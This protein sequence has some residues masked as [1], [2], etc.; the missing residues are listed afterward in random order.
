M[1]RPSGDA[2]QIQAVTSGKRFP[3]NP[4]FFRERSPGPRCPLNA[5]LHTSPRGGGG[6][7]RTFQ[8]RRSRP[9]WSGWLLCLIPLELLLSL[10]RAC[11]LEEG[12]LTSY[13]ECRTC[14]LGGSAVGSAPGTPWCPRPP[15]PVSRHAPQLPAE[16]AVNV[17]R[18]FAALTVKAPA[19]CPGRRG[20]PGARTRAFV[21]RPPPE[22]T[23]GLEAAPRSHFPGSSASQRLL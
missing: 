8:R 22:L 23:P 16:A 15:P 1:P 10:H 13:S 12:A 7:G 2:L 3:C 9:P 19:L 11:Y 5:A 14:R 18:E 17:S 21:L 6:P 20:D 4:Q